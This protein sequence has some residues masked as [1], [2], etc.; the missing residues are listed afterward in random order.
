MWEKLILKERITSDISLHDE[1][2]VQHTQIGV[3]SVEMELSEIDEC[4]SS[5]MDKTI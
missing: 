5:N 4:V 1:C 2:D 3:G